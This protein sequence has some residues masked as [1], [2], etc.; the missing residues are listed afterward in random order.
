VLSLSPAVAALSGFV[1]RDQQ[2]SLAQW[3]GVVLVMVAS[4]AAVTGAEP[5][6]A[7]ASSAL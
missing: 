7:A 4:A 2:L 6:D 1:I 3:V 5:P